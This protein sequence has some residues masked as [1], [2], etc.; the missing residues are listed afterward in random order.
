VL[1]A[2]VGVALRAILAS[3]LLGAALSML[4][5]IA[6]RRLALTA[7]TRHALWTTAM[8]AT[9]VMPL[10]GIAVSLARATPGEAA[11]A[12]TLPVT[13]TATHWRAD[14]HA[15]RVL[16]AGTSSGSG[17]QSPGPVAAAELRSLPVALAAWT[18][19]VTRALALGVVGAWSLGALI[20][21]IGLAASLVRIRG[22]KRRSSPLDGALADELPWLTAASSGREIY[23]RLSYEIETP[24]AIGFGR[25]VILIPTELAGQ[26]GLAA[27]EPL[28]LHEHAH[29]RRYDDWTN[30]IQRTIER[31]FWFNPIVWLV[32]RR[33]ALER[34][35]ASDD[36]VV[37]KTGEAHAYATSLWRLAREMRMP[38]H[39]VVAPGALLT[40]KQIAVRIEQLLDTDRGRLRRSPGAAIV[41][42][43][44]GIVAVAFVAT[45]APAVELPTPPEPVPAAWAPPK[46]AAA[47]RAPS[48]VAQAPHQLTKIVIERIAAKPLETAPPRTV[49]VYVTPHPAAAKPVTRS[50][51]VTKSV[52][53]EPAAPQPVAVVPPVPEPPRVPAPDFPAAAA[54]APLPARPAPS[55]ATYSPRTLA[56]LR[57]AASHSGNTA[58]TLGSEFGTAVVSVVSRALAH[59]PAEL[60]Q[61]DRDEMPSHRIVPA[62]M[63]I[64]REI[65]TSCNGCS[66]RNADLR[67][68]DLH[69]LTLKGDD[70]SG[71]DLRDVNL[72][73]AN[74]IGVSLRRANLGSADLRGA[75]LS[76]VE[77]SGASLAGARLDDMTLVGVSLRSPGVSGVSMRSMISRCTG[78][79]LTNVDLHGQD[80]HGIVLTGADLSHADLHGAN[81]SGAHFMGVDFS[82]VNLSG[83]DLTNARLDGCDLHGVS[84]RDAITTGMTLHGSSQDG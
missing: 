76:G 57:A 10:A 33:I 82:G 29:L 59:L 74:L 58:A 56:A 13:T 61:V 9:A 55:T 60:A 64:S 80:L 16:A 67:G 79:D 25:P 46:P 7:A 63:K 34:E 72:A 77:L 5:L 8:I 70:F 52:A 51:A 19:R 83:A 81:L 50:S 65:L 44:A 23:L 32:G 28:V 37:E 3:V 84:L 30:L 18:P 41:T 20:G 45:S 21:M 42:A 73:G 69:D 36:A 78:C 11:T 2:V 14:A 66:F 38:E 15:S 26:G 17:A 47:V 12:R 62:G 39:A 75:H 24:V 54:R 43:L 40:R 31:V 1:E 27:L 22:L 48:R 53:V 71:A 68:L 49:Y 4:V 6:T 35:I